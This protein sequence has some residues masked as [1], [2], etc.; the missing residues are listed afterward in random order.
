MKVNIKNTAF[1][2][3]L[4][5]F[6]ALYSQALG[7]LPNYH[8]IGFKITN[9]G[10][11]DSCHVFYRKFGNSDWLRAYPPDRITL[12]KNAQFRGS[13]FLLDENT[14]Y[15]VKATLFLTGT[16][17]NIA[18]VSDTTLLSPSFQA[19]SNVK[20]VSPAG[21]GT[22]YTQSQPGNIATLF[23]SGGVSCGTT[24][25]L[26]DGIYT[27]NDLRLQLNKHCTANSPIV[28]MAAPG[29]KPI[30]D[31][32]VQLNSGW[33]QDAN[34]K[35]LYSRAL[36]AGAA[37]TNIC[38][39]GNRALYPYP[40]YQSEI[41][42]AGYHLAALNFGYDGFVRN[43]T[44]IWIKTAAGENPN[45]AGVIVS[46]AYRFLTVYGNNF[47]AYL[48][49]KGLEFRHFAKPFLN[50]LGADINSLQAQVFDIRNAHHI[51]FD[52]CT[53]RHNTAD[54]VF[55]RV[56]NHILFQHCTFKHDVGKWSH[57]MVKRSRDFVHTLFFTLST[58]RGRSVESGGV[59][60][61]S[62]IGFVVRNN[63]FDGTNSGVEGP[64]D[65]GIHEE[66]DVYN[67]VFTDNYDGLEC[68][69]NWVNLRAWSNR[70]VNCMAGISAAPPLLGPR[71]FY[72][73]I[74]YGMKGR[75]TDKDD[76]YFVGCKPVGVNYQSQGL[77]IKTNSNYTG[78]GSPGSMFFFNNTFHASDTLGFVITSMKSEWKDAVF[79][80][81]SFSHD[82]VHPIYFFALGDKSVNSSYRLSSVYDNFYNYSSGPVVV[83]N[84]IYGQ[85]QCSSVLNVVNLQSTLRTISGSAHI[86]VVGAGPSNPAFTN[87]SIGDF[88]LTSGSGL[89]DAGVRIPGF[90]DFK[91]KAPDVGAVESSHQGSMSVATRSRS[92]LTVFPNP[93]TGSFVVGIPPGENLSA[94]Q[95]YSTN[96]ALLL[97][98]PVAAQQP[99]EIKSLK[100]GVYILKATFANQSQ[101]NC[102]ILVV[103]N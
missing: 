3:M 46:A 6:T 28:I 89:V 56:C 19:T 43:E 96:A 69:G 45:T 36:P 23:S 62:G 14:A 67:N 94:I 39:L 49:I 79:I 64:F 41:T 29:A 76:S 80:N 61:D 32:G 34:D 73:N 72:R 54:V 44:G 81:N 24:V 17:Q 75:R 103:N 53:F 38:I 95:L 5:S 22:A 66:S 8:S 30:F 101:S 42:M 4:F 20:W 26:A 31:G 87:K 83:A 15:E 82:V 40:S 27:Q 9:I 102:K 98:I 33:Q 100:P 13:I 35:T 16:P 10:S 18:A 11:A 88:S 57:T 63:L 70:F 86:H 48:K 65:D 12:N 84:S 37:H 92:G 91:G 55:E 68:D 78:N 60:H 25:M 51:S 97:S 47:N 93:S 74:F 7:L 59:F 50:P 71:Y 2:V 90:P 85:Y 52:S 1:L 99:I 58:S 77:A 21:S